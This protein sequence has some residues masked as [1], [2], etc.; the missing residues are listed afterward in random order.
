MPQEYRGQFPLIK[1]LDK[2]PVVIK[3]RI[4]FR[5][6]KIASDVPLFPLQKRLIF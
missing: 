3:D 4:K 2:I 5:F 6:W 1:G